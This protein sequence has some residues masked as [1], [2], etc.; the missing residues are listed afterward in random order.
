MQSDL[1]MN[2]C[3]LKSKVKRGTLATWQWEQS[4][5]QML[6]IGQAAKR[7]DAIEVFNRGVQVVIT[8]IEN[9]THPTNS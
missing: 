9:R 4:T 2:T 7:W 6:N 1:K 5:S 3:D 8:K